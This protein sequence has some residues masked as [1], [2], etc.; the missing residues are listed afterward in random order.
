[1]RS[2]CIPHTELPGT[3]ALFADY[4]Y[5]FERVAKFY[6]HNPHDPESVR[7]A[8]IAAAIPDERRQKVVAALRK[9]NGESASLAQLELPDTVAIVTGQQVGLFSGP[10]YTVYKALTAAKLA[11]QL[12]D[13]GVR[14]VPVFW[15]ATEDHDFQEIQ[16]AW[17]FDPRQRA[18]RLEASGAGQ[19]GQPVGSIP[20]TS[21]PVDQLRET[22]RGFLYADEVMELVDDAYK[23]GR[24]FGEAFRILIQRLL[25]GHGLVFLDPLEPGLREVAAPMLHAALERRGELTQALMARGR[26]LEA[27]GYHSQ[28]L[29]DKDTSLFF[30]LEGGRRL[31]L[32]PEEVPS[33]S[34]SLSPNALLRPVMQDYLLPTAAY[35]GGPAELAYLAQSQV[36]YQTLL[37]RMPMAVP[38]SGFTLLDERAHTLMEKYHI[39]LTDC[40]H[41]SDSLKERIAGRL[42]PES[43]GATFEDV[44]S[45]VRSSLDRLERELHTF[46]PTLGAAMVKSRA[47][48]LYQLEKNRRKTSR[49]AMRRNLQVTEGAAHLSGLVF[50]ERH[51]QERLFSLLPFLARH[52]FDLIDSL[53]EN[54]HRGCPDHLLL[55]V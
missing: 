26:D 33:D 1:M 23:P 50:P 18:A 42:I 19:P 39:T 44:S 15:L 9:I 28:V 49:E 35:I 54:V 37:G 17:M 7:R 27:A 48:I 16:H 45:E 20:I 3:S 5:R 46:D 29:V 12:T 51:L 13:S 6:A 40:F 4:L 14:A 21:A 22:L 2:T 53:Y 43:L 41:G 24:T 32:G 34:A 38:R 8:A 52:G 30:K 10:A 55:T 11:R 47:K 25:A 36:L 31:K